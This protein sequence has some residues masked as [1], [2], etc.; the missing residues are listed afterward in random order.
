MLNQHLQRKTFRIRLAEPSDFDALE[1]LERKAW[2]KE[3]QATSEVGSPLKGG[4]GGRGG[5]VGLIDGE[6]KVGDDC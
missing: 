4:R 5:R 6:K 3:L 2:A 1:A